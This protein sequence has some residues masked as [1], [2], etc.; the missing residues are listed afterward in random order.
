MKTTRSLAAKWTTSSAKNTAGH[1]GRKP[2]V[3][4]YLLQ[5]G[6]RQRPWIN[7]AG[8]GTYVRFFNPRTDRWA[9]HFTLD[10][11]LILAHSDIGEVTARILEFNHSDR[12]L[13]RQVLRAVSRYPTAAAVAHI[14]HR[15]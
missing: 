13:E 6:Q 7:G 14:T 10:G 8:T 12:L 5:S 2:R 11:V 15:T 3:C 4:V 9:E 1:G